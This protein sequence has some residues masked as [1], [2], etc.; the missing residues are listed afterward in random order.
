MKPEFEEPK[1]FKWGTFKNAKGADVRYGCLKSADG[2]PKGT[3][4]ITPGFRECIEKYFEVVND[5]AAK[6]YDVWI[7]DWR[8][9]GGSQRFIKDSQKAHHEGY[10]EQ[11]ETLKQFSTS[12]VDKQKDPLVLMA[13]SMGAHIA[14][15]FLKEHEGVFDSAILTSPMLDIQTGTLPK[16]LAR[17]MAKFAKAG[18]YLEKY[19]PGGTDWDEGKHATFKDNTVTSDAERFKVVKEI[20]DRNPDLKIGDPTYGWVYHTFLSIDTLNQE[21]YLKSIKTPIL[22][23]VSDN[24]KIVVRGA[25]ERACKLM[26]NCEKFEIPGARHEIWMERDDLRDVWK[27]RVDNFLDDRRNGVVFD[28]KK[29]KPQVKQKP[30][31]P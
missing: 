31:K 29:D 18:G 12:V 19:I 30:P 27:K 1:D 20:Y 11:I 15:R 5:M 9:Q 26:P 6:G 25:Q 13:H 16:P 28:P 21:E 3:L 22:M 14:L 24:D 17:Q 23:Q 7:M 2:A 4:V 10:D 8:G